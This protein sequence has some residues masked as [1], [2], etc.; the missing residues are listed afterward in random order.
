MH[1]DQ[2]QVPQLSLERGLPG[3]IAQDGPLICA[4]HR[5]LGVGIEDDPGVTDGKQD[6][7]DRDVLTRSP[8]F[9]HGRR[10]TDEMP[11]R[12]RSSRSRFDEQR[13]CR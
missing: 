5:S 2:T 1:G 6:D 10:P 11:R 4:G 8:G 12:Y 13:D 7:L 9:S 3:R